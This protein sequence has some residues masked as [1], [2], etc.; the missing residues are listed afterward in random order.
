MTPAAADRL[1]RLRNFQSTEWYAALIVRPLTIA[2]LWLCADWRW[3]TPNRCTTVGN[4]AKLGAAALI[5]TPDHWVAAAVLL[6]VGVLF[7][8]MDGT[9]A[10]YRRA[11]TKLGSFYDK[12]SDMITWAAI[13][14]AAGW[15][16]A[17]AEGE[18]GYLVL[19]LAGVTGMNVCGYMKWLAHAESERVRWLEAQADPVAAVMARTRPIA[20]AP[21]PTRTRG[22]WL[23]WGLTMASRVWRFEEVDLWFWL[24]L[25]LVIGRLDLAVWVLS[26]TQV[27]QLVIMIGVRTRDVVRAD[28][29][30]RELEGKG[31]GAPLG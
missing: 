5:L 11:F 30:I 16:V 15:Q 4:L 29:R 1:R 24:G 13:M 19:A 20:I 18:P 9:L 27:A 26:A 22:Q 10:R 8:H 7:D 23:R 21:P 17:R 31:E 14:G 2:V 6:Q 12:V 25:A 28:R 3:V